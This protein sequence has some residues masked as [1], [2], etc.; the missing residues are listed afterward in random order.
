MVRVRVLFAAIVQVLGEPLERVPG[1]RVG[2]VAEGIVQ[3]RFGC[4][5][6][7]GGREVEG[8]AAGLVE[9]DGPNRVGAQREGDGDGWGF[10]V[11]GDCQIAAGGAE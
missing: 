8:W 2:S 9:A 3:G 4:V 7:L 5:A 10:E 11:W 6:E 1:V